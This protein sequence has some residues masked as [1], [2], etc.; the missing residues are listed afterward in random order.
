M[1]EKGESNRMNLMTLNNDRS[2]AAQHHRSTAARQHRST[3][4]RQHRSTAAR[5]HFLTLCSSLR[6][7]RS[8]PY[9]LCSMLHALCSMPLPQH[10]STAALQ[11]FLTL[12]SSLRAL[13]SMPYA[14]CFYRSTAAQQHRS[15]FISILY[16]PC[17][18]LYALRSVL[19]SLCSF[20]LCSL[21]LFLPSFVRAEVGDLFKY[22]QPYIAVQEEY[23]SN[24]DLTPTNRREDYITTVSPGLRISTLPRGEV[25]RRQQVPTAE[26]RFG[27]DFDFNAGF[28]FYA[29]E[30]DNNYTRLSGNVNAWYFFDPR[31]SLRLRNYLIRSDEIRETDY[32]AT[33]IQGQTLISRTIRRVPYYRNVFEPSLEYRFGRENIFGLSYRNNIYEIKSRIYEDSMENYV[34]PR[35]TYWFNI[36]N[37]I[38]LSYGFTAGDFE[39][40]PDLIGHAVTGRYTY[41]FNPRTS[42]FGEYAYL[43]RDFDPP[44][45]D[46]EVHRPSLGISH[47]FSRTLSVTVQGG[48]YWQDPERGPKAEGLFYDVS[49]TERAERTTYSIALQGGYTEDFFTAENLGF[50][51]YYR[52]IGRIS[53][54]L[55]ERMTVGGFGSYERIKYSRDTA[56]G[57]RQIDRIFSVGGDAAYRLF[58]WLTF[59][60][61]ASFRENHSNLDT[62]DYT[63]Y[64]GIFR[65]T[66]SF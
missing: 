18:M 40:S 21:L 28:V 48:Y 12:C 32:S 59:S 51:K 64:R 58:R 36:R 19:R 5:Q 8:L 66:A 61:E 10:R 2:T 6:A 35:L 23:N 7:L 38:A 43:L 27:L 49:V 54:Q 65:I 13:C 31:L 16:A 42:V 50:T 62:A 17:S 15:T 33:A 14:L 11:H 22:L 44:S 53:H 63:E 30:E 55:L 1:G 41:R 37:G 57:P 45:I 20:A 25:T 47:A 52:G 24:I 60:L 9:A 46:Y 56:A 3:A 26:Q 39:R 4:A 29:K 34:S